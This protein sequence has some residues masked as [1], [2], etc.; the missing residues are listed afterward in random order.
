MKFDKSRLY[1][2]A[3]ADEVKVGS[4]GFVADNLYGLKTKVE[5]GEDTY[6]IVEI[7]CIN[8]ET[9]NTRFCIEND[10][11][12]SFHLFYLVE[13]PKEKK[14]R[15]YKNTDEMVEDFKKR[16]NSYGGWSGKDNLMYYPLIWIRPKTGK[17]MYLITRFAINNNEVTFTCDSSC[18]SLNLNRLFDEY[19]YL[20]DSLCGVEE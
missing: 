11:P 10:G 7:A 17:N 18:Y 1:T 16:Y 15:P 5:A 2:A 6:S 4:K 19:T 14:F 13:E 20:D 8:D 9:K 12:E 3:N